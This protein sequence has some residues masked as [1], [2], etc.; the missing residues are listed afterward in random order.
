MYPYSCRV[1]P[2]F[3]IHMHAGKKLGIPTRV[4]SF[5]DPRSITDSQLLTPRP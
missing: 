5:A 3:D 1:L 2:T 4:F